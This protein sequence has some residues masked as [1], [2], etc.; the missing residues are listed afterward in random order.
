MVYSILIVDDDEDDFDLLNLHVK[1]CHHQLTVAYTQ[2][3][4]EAVRKLTEGMSPNLIVVD[5]HMPIMDGYELLE[6]IMNSEACRH[7]PVI[8]WTGDMSSSDVF[9]YYKAGANAVMLKESALKDVESFCHYW[10]SMVQLP[11][12]V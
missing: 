8:V 12:A 4:V 10:F 6:W 3:G 7:I 5:A 9:R 2:N 1:R 11:K